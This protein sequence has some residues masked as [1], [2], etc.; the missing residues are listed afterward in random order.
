MR[1]PPANP[2]ASGTSF[3]RFPVAEYRICATK[4]EQVSV[5]Q[6]LK[7]VFAVKRKFP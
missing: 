7:S 2:R 3:A 4:N 5:F 6:L 1:Y